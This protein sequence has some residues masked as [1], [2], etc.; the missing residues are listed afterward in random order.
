MTHGQS[1]LVLGFVGIVAA[2]IPIVL[3]AGW[4]A[5]S[6]HLGDPDR[7]VEF[8][9]YGPVIAG[10]LSLGTVAVHLSIIGDHATHAAPTGNAVLFLCAV[11]AVTAHPAVVDARV[12]GFLPAGLASLFLTPIQTVWSW[13]RAWRSHGAVIVGVVVALV[14]LAIT[15][16]QLAMQPLLVG[17]TAA[18]AQIGEAGVLALVVEG[19]LLGAVALRLAG[20]PRRLV[21]ALRLRTIDA[22]VLTSLAVVAVCIF[23]AVAL[24]AGHDAH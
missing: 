24:G 21:A 14:A 16:T 19:M 9:G 3:I 5:R 8:A 1:A 20:R 23:S 18:V 6:G 13:P 22:L 17:P 7:R 15:V 12:L 2:F 4:L 10:A 11:G